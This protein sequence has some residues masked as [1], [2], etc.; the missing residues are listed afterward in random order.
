MRKYYLLLIFSWITLLSFGQ[1][2][3]VVVDG[4]FLTL[5]KSQAINYI[6]FNNIRD[7]TLVSADSAKVLIGDYGKNG[8]FV[9]RTKLPKGQLPKPL[10]TKD[11]LYFTNTPTILVNDSLAHNFNLQAIDPKK[12]D[13]VRIVTPLSAVQ[14]KGPDWVGGMIK[15][16]LRQ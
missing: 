9:I 2:P 1:G 7:T 14:E 16:Y 4:F 8:L 13:S 3:I 10:M 15:I 6:G 11:K 12:V 5:N